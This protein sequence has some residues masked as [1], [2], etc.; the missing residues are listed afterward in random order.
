MVLKFFYKLA[1]LQVQVAQVIV[2]IGFSNSNKELKWNEGDFSWI[3]GD[4]FSYKF[5]TTIMQ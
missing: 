3:S 1:T 4:A 5:L 2:E